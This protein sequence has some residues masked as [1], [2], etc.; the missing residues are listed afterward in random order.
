MS[1][2][3]YFTV[4]DLKL[5]IRIIGHLVVAYLSPSGKIFQIQNISTF[6]A[7]CKAHGYEYLFLYSRN[8]Y[9]QGVCQ[10]NAPVRVLNLDITAEAFF[11]PK[12][13]ILLQTV[14]FRPSGP[15]QCSADARMKVKLCSHLKRS[16]TCG[17]I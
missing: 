14:L 17:I 16:H 8:F 1:K 5:P 7:V 10:Q 3:K 13:Y 6:K 15:H 9:F 12:S 2:R 4:L 11:M